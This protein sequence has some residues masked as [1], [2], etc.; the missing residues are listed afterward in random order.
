MID[1]ATD[2]AVQNLEDASDRGREPADGQV[3]VEE[4]GR[5][6]GAGHQVVQIVGEFGQLDDLALVL[7]VDRMQ[8]FVDRLQ[9][10]VGALQ[11]LVAGQ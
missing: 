9:L 4:Q 11:L 10:L 7:G 8:F 5:D 2:V 1:R 6:P 3:F